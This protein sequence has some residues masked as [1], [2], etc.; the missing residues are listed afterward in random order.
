[1]DEPKLLLKIRSDKDQNEVLRIGEAARG[2]APVS[3]SL[4]DGI[5]QVNLDVV[6][7]LHPA[8]AAFEAEAAGPSE[9][10]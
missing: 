3:S 6:R 2:I 8:R 7:A 4:Y 1:M 9:G 5:F 10:P